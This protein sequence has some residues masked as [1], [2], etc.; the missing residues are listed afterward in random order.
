MNIFL[1]KLGPSLKG[2]EGNP[3]YPCLIGCSNLFTEF[4]LT[5][6]DVL[7]NNLK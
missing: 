1:L 3:T 2:K 7:E 4:S 6:C 5:K